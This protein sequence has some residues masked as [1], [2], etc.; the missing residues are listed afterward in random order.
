MWCLLGNKLLLLKLKAPT[1]LGSKQEIFLNF[2]FFVNQLSLF[3]NHRA[4]EGKN[5]IYSQPSLGLL[6]TKTG[7]ANLSSILLSAK[8]QIHPANI[9]D[10]F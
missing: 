8:Q 10:K 1:K 6:A 7:L 2:S 9:W 4:F 5:H 3:D